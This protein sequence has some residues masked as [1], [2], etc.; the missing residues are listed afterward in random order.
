MTGIRLGEGKYTARGAISMHV[1]G[2]K[3]QLWGSGLASYTPVATEKWAGCWCSSQASVG[4]GMG[5]SRGI[6]ATGRNT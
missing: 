1:H 3:H 2:G 6:R 5:G 4:A